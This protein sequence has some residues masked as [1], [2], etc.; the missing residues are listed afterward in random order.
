M[1]IRNVTAKSL[2]RNGIA[3]GASFVFIAK[4]PQGGIQTRTRS[5]R[6]RQ[7]RRQTQPLALSAREQIKRKRKERRIMR[8]SA[9]EEHASTRSPALSLARSRRR[10]RSRSLL[11]C[12]L[13]SA[14]E[15]ARESERAR[16]F[17]IKLLTLITAIFES[18]SSSLPATSVVLR[19]MISTFIWV[20]PGGGRGEGAEGYLNAP[21]GLVL[22]SN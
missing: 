5:R 13:I 18:S 2:S 8:E 14:S 12:I 15:R 4:E 20:W 1:R 22:N 3:K 11:R 7:R 16:M 6:R 9:R 17:G 10:S 21:T 19:Q